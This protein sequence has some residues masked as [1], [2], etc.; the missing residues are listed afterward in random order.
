MKYKNKILILLISLI[1]LISCAYVSAD[2]TIIIPNSGFEESSQGKASYW[3]T[4][5]YERDYQNNTDI[6]EFGLDKEEKHSGKSSVYII[7]KS[8]NDARYKQV[9][10]VVPNSYYKISSWVKTLNVGLENKGASIS[11]VDIIETSIDIKGTNGKWELIELYGKTDIGQNTFTVTLGLG[12]YGS[13][14]VGKVWFDDIIIEK[15]DSIPP[16]KTAINLYS[17][18]SKNTKEASTKNNFLWILIIA[19]C[20]LFATASLYLVLKSKKIDNKKKIRNTDI[21][22]GTKGT[23]SKGKQEEY[24]KMVLDKKDKTIMGT[25]IF[26]YIIIALINLGSMKV[27][28]TT[29]NPVKPGES[30]TIDLGRTIDISRITYYC[31]LGTGWSAKGVYKVEYMN[32]KGEYVPLATLQ[33]K[34]G[35]VFTWKY[36]DV[37]A[38]TNKLKIYVDVPGGALNEIGIYEKGSKEPIQGIKIIDKNTDSLDGGSVEN[39]FDEQSYVAYNS[40]YMNSTYFDEIYH[41]RTAYEHLNKIEPFESTHPPLGKVFIS[42][43]ISIFGMTPFGFRIIGTLFG[44]AMIPLMYMFGM[45][46]FRKRFYAFCAAFLMMFDFMHFT[47]TRIATIDVYVTFFIILMFYY[48]YDYFMKKSYKIDFK[49]SLKPL[50]LSGLFFGFGLASKWIALFGAAGLTFIFFLAKYL[51]YLDYSKI[52]NSKKGK[53]QTWIKNFIPIYMNG[54]F[55]VCI[56]FFVLIPLIIYILSYI[57]FMSV[58]GPGHGLKDVF[59]YQTHMYNYHNNL[60]ASHP[61]YSSWWQWPLMIKP[62]WFYSGSGLEV[63]RSS[64]IATL[65]NPAIWWTSIIA[66]PIAML[67]ALIKKEKKMI[68]VFTAIIALYLPW[69]FVSRIAFIY[70]FFSILP[71]AI[72]SIVYVIKNT[73]EKYPLS[74]Y[75]IYAYLTITAILFIVFYPALSAME[76]DSSYI[77]F[78]KWFKSWSF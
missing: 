5:D 16:G 62:V 63:G 72:L 4:Y 59:T 76:V 11:T 54:T 43:G 74:K 64:T 20:I 32:E 66:I 13:V 41:A 70:H 21:K 3:A 48:M 23:F 14:N 71:F 60:N 34:E 47:L 68:V 9:I 65:G 75:I 58:P 57:P 35:F 8:L 17:G 29:W 49:K 55:I 39:L 1:I 73:I 24:K 46:L 45:K 52:K 78:L 38:S 42:L 44:V 37:S 19:V 77:Q 51:E 40:N 50:F 10:K 15:I 18:E 22:E 31:G 12:G 69:V 26:I 25:M 6:T 36:V 28:Q 56:V 7:N 2:S 53:R 30:V 61:F 33:K 67:I 27:P